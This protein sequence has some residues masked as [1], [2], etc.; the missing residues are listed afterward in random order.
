MNVG[1]P[2]LVQPY[3]PQPD[4]VQPYIAQPYLVEPYIAQP[5][6][7]QPYLAK[8]DLDQPDVAGLKLACPTLLICLA[9]LYPAQLGQDKLCS[10]VLT[11]QYYFSRG[12]Y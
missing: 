11:Y 3:L 9:K 1:K 12:E 7:V 10:A 8:P 6:L 4:L 2:D 5:Y